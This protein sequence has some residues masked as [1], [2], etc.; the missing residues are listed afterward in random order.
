MASWNDQVIADFRANDGVLGGPWAGKTV[1]LLHA[2]GRRTGKEFVNP[3]VAAPDGDDFVICGSMGGAPA[4][5]QWVSNL[6]AASGPA[7]I[8]IGTRTVKADCTV[9]RPDDPDWARLYGIWRTYWPGAAE[10]EKK[11]DRKFP[12]ATVHIV[13]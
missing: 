4:D 13:D 10:Y 5:P 3:L 2:V 1:L 6:E 12:V 8:E 11:T 7:T 9:V